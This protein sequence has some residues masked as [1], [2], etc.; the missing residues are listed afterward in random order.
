M[1]DPE[2]AA[3]VSRWLGPVS[4]ALEVGEGW[5]YGGEGGAI[6]WEVGNWGRRDGQVGAII[7]CQA[8]HSLSVP[9]SP[10]PRGPNLHS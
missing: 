3:G 5:C 2:F 4:G 10:N 1:F 8:T 7:P 9:G 6:G